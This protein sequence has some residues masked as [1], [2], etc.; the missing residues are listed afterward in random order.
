MKSLNPFIGGMTWG[1][2]G[3]RGTW[4]NPSAEHSMEEM[5]RTLSVNWTTIAFSALQETAHSTEILFEDEPTVTDTEV[6]WAIQKAQSLGLQVCLKPI[7]NCADGTWRAHINF[8]DIDVPCEPK[9]SEWFSSYTRF[10]LHYAA[11]AEELGCE[12]FCVGCEMVQTDRRETQWRQ[13]IHDVRQVYSGIVTYNCDKYQ[14][15]QVKWWDAVDMIS[16]SGYYP[17]NTWEEQLDRIEQVVQQY[18]KP[19]F[20][21]EVGCPSRTG[22]QHLPN[23]WSLQGDPNE[24]EQAQFYRVMFDQCSKRD[25]VQGFMLWDWKANLYDP[26]DASSDDDYCPYGKKAEGIINRQYELLKN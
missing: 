11:I 7:V 12:M 26:Q 15:D 17:I 18:D 1:F 10:I 14:E 24:E 13:L 9:W 16:S 2:T 23:D 6:R 22:S 5:V 20:F 3:V 4:N 8:F 25:W 19:F 21:M